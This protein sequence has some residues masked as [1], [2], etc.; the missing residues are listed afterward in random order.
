MT[1]TT[2]FRSHSV[3][4]ALGAGL[5]A[6]I[7]LG[8]CARLISLTPPEPGGSAPTD[9]VATRIALIL[10]L[11][12]PLDLTPEQI[13]QLMRV[14]HDTDQIARA[15]ATT[16]RVQ[17]VNLAKLLA[18]NPPNLERAE[19]TIRALAAARGELRI[20]QLRGVTRA[21]ALLTDAQQRRLVTL[22]LSLDTLAPPG[23][24]TANEAPAREI[25]RD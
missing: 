9:P 17:E 11:Q 23:P 18:E 7:L 21:L 13:Y 10:R 16:L 25:S 6:L 4:L 14:V 8:G 12:E 22:G 3:T 2:F 19:A 24:G 5:L 15:H 20:E 1:L